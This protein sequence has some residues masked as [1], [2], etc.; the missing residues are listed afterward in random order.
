MKNINA[1]LIFNGNCRQA[2]EFYQECLGGVLYTMPYSAMPGAENI[3]Q[4]CQDWVLHAR[5]TIKSVVLMAS[6]TRP[7]VAITQGN[8]FFVSVSC[9]SIEETERIFN[10]LSENGK[11][12]TP[13]A[14]TFFARRFGMLTDQFGIHWMFNL[15]KP[16]E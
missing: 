11:I 14:E 15:E 10:C 13:L 7:G 5:L 2:M 1:Y 16:K 3:P 8:N 6:D 4:E 12:T 9:E